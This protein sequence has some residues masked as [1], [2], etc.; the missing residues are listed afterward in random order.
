MSEQ[1]EY[2]WLN[3]L[4]QK[5]LEKD[6]LLPGQTVD[7]RITQICENAERILNKPGFAEKLKGY[8][9]KGWYTFSTPVLANFGTDRALPISC[10]GTMIED[11]ME[12]ILQAQCEIG[13]LTKYGG[14]TSAYVG[15][16]RE[17]GATIKN[18]G[19]SAGPVHFSQLY[20]T[21]IDVVSQ[22]SLRRGSCAIYMQLEHP[23]IK[24]FLK[25]RSDGHP[26]QHLLFGVC[27]SDQFMEKMIAGDKQS[28]EIWA[29]VLDCRL[30]KGL[31]ISSLVGTLINT[32]Q[33]YTKIWVWRLLIVIFVRKS[34]NVIPQKKPLFVTLA[35]W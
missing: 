33:M 2:R 15:K 7:E 9:K 31:L 17:R 13:M 24:E 6:Y 29:L 27:V 14:G 21:T 25:I 5:F 32:R 16:L 10:F 30:K 35:L 28:R 3:D 20:N 23:D 8:V 11:S 18:N 4:S 1:S 26:I 19:H 34:W 22:G 12:S